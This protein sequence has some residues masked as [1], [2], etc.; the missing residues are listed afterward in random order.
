MKRQGCRQPLVI[1]VVL[2]IFADFAMSGMLS[3]FGVLAPI[4]IPMFMMVGL[5][6]ELTTAAYRIGDSVVNVI[7][8]LNSYA[9]IILAMF[10]KFRPRAGLGT[11][12]ALMVPYSVALAVAWTGA[13]LIWLA[14][15]I[16]LGP[17]APL[18][19]LGR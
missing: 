16:D 19:V 3:K 2:V 17:G 4:A 1:F 11:L 12:I 6:P 7:T 8:P 5:S 10:Q 9:L 18:T 14:L 15:G 13:L